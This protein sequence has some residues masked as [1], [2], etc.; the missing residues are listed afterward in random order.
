MQFKLGFLICLLVCT[1]ITNTYA[2][3]C[4]STYQNQ[5]FKSAIIRVDGFEVR[6]NYR[7]NN[8]SNEITYYI[9]N[10]IQDSY[11]PTYGNWTVKVPRIWECS[12]IISNDC[13]F[14]KQ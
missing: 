2:L 3:T 7:G 4:D 6:C 9:G 1:S 11:V 10:S 14:E 8:E 13:G 12:A 5:A